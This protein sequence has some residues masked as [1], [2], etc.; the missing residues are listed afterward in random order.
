L[1][2]PKR[3]TDPATPL[4]PGYIFARVASSSDDLLRIRAAPGVSYI[5]PRAAPPA[6][7]PK[8]LVDELRAS[9]SDRA[10][11]EAP[12]FRSGDRVTVA[13]GPL[14]WADAVFD[15]YVNGAGRVRILLAMVHQTVAVDMKDEYL[16][17]S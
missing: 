5:L 6:L 2:R 14:R 11:E 3:R 16:K 8:S 13:A 10:R 17:R 12:R 15:R 7:L 9:E 4:F 1:L